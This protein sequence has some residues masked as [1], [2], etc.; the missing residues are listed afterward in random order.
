MK[1]NQ[2]V[3]ITGATSGIGLELAKL[4]AKDGYNLIIVA[5]HQLELERVSKELKDQNNIAVIPIS[6]DLFDRSAAF[7][8][9]EQ[10]K[11]NGFEVNILVNDA[12]QGNYGLFTDVDLQKDLDIIQL[13][14]TSLVTLTKLFLKDMVKRGE[15]K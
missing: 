7:E 8:L 4:F 14:I 12:G 15:G 11:A 9:Y 6:K 3:L 10:V 1:T 2:Y 5:R 13:N